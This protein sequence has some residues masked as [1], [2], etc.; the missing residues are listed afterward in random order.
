[1]SIT[2]VQ[3]ERTKLGIETD[4]FGFEKGISDP[5]LFTHD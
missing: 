5:L 4:H 3:H 2:T 1:M